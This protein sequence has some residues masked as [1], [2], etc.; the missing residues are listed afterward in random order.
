MDPN[1]EEQIVLDEGEDLGE[2]DMSPSPKQID[3]LKT[4]L[5]NRDSLIKR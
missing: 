2:E 5:T 4:A 3:E 1:S